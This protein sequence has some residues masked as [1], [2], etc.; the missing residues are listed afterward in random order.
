MA[1][2]KL[3]FGG[4]GG[5]DDPDWIKDKTKVAAYQDWYNAKYP[6][7]A[8]NFGL[9]N[10]YKGMW[11]PQSR[12]S[13]K[14]AG[15][16][17]TDYTSTPK[18]DM[19]AIKPPDFTPGAPT[20]M[21]STPGNLS[22]PVYRK[23][24]HNEG[25]PTTIRTGGTQRHT[26]SAPITP[27]VSWQDR[28]K[29]IAPY[30]SNIINTF[31]RAPKSPEPHLD[32][33]VTLQ[34]VNMSNDLNEVG[35]DVYAANRSSDM[36]LD[37]NSAAAVKQYTLAQSFANKSKIRESERNANMEI[38]NREMQINAGITASNNN[39]LDLQSRDNVERRV[40]NQQFGAENLANAADK[41][42]AIQNEGAK[43]TLEGKKLEVIKSMY[44]GDGVATRAFK[45]LQDIMQDPAGVEF[46]A[47]GKKAKMTDQQLI[48]KW[49]EAKKRGLKA[50][51]TLITTSNKYGG[52]L[53]YSTGGM[54]KLF[55]S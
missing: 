6:K 25:N 9:N 53:K 44:D 16:D 17:Y 51:R 19:S 26:K 46:I 43:A 42:Q 49:E 37:E 36:N 21:P 4:I 39:K 13:W 7:N 41:Y 14:I 35:K 12:R 20:L 32:P 22:T 5:E 28:A 15:K 47:A 30:A 11:G 34:R 40:A 55:N 1:L 10:V 8:I 48:D 29:S 54:M 33:L 50:D 2:K 45:K 31:R 24:T 18:L 23:P 38:S 52:E 27:S 3:L